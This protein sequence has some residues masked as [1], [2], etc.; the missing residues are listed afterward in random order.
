MILLVSGGGHHLRASS[1]AGWFILS[2]QEILYRD[3]VT[4]LLIQEVDPEEI[5]PYT[6][7]LR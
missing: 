3:P 7:A 6:R 1:K 4:G 5:V 2:D